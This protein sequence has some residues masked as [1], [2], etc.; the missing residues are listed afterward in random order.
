MWEACTGQL[1]K[2]F[3]SLSR[4]DISGLT[5]DKGRRK[6][7]LSNLDGDLCFHNYFNGAL[8]RQIKHKGGYELSSLMHAGESQLLLTVSSDRALRVVDEVAVSETDCMLRLVT[9]AHMSD[10][11]VSAFDEPLGL[12]ATGAEDGLLKIWD[13]EFM[14]LEA[15]LPCPNELSALAFASPYPLLLLGDSTGALT[16]LP[17]RPWAGRR[18]RAYTPAAKWQCQGLPASAARPLLD[19]Q[20]TEDRRYAPAAIACLSVV[21]FEQ[22]GVERQLVY[23]ANASG[24]I[25]AYDL[26]VVLEGLQMGPCA[27]GDLPGQKPNFN[28]RRKVVRRSSGDGAK[29]GLNASMNRSSNLGASGGSEADAAAVLDNGL[30]ASCLLHAWVAHEEVIVCMSVLQQPQVLFTCSQD[31]SVKLWGYNGAALGVLTWGRQADLSQRRFWHFP[32][33]FSER[34]R[35]RTRRALRIL[36]SLRAHHG[37]TVARFLGDGDGEEGNGEERLRKLPSLRSPR[38]GPKSPPQSPKAVPLATVSIQQDS[39]D[40][41][42]ATG[43]NE[44]EE[45]VSRILGQLH[46]MSTWRGDQWDKKGHKGGELGSSY[47]HA[48]KEK[49]LHDRHESAAAKRRRRRRHNDGRRKRDPIL[50]TIKSVDRVVAKY[51]HADQ[52]H[53]LAAQKM[54]AKKESGGKEEKDPLGCYDVL[55]AAYEERHHVMYPHLHADKDKLAA[56]SEFSRAL[57]KLQGLK[58]LLDEADAVQA[59]NANGATVNAGSPLPSA[60]RGVRLAEEGGGPND[61]PL[62]ASRPQTAATNVS[63]VSGVSGASE[64]GEARPSNVESGGEAVAP[65]PR[66]D[67]STTRVDATPRRSLTARIRTSIDHAGATQRGSVTMQ[68][69]T[70]RSNAST[71]GMTQRTMQGGMTMKGSTGRATLKLSLSVGH[72]LL[73]VK[74][75]AVVTK[76][77]EGEGREGNEGRE[78]GARKAGGQREA[79]ARL[80]KPTMASTHMEAPAKHHDK[81]REAM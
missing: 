64:G 75:G 55:R 51:A 19:G 54:Y 78:E 6:L 7:I 21:T 63:G 52:L 29:D 13:A 9:Q 66:V 80:T 18:P 61:D 15:S 37:G 77:E 71:Q 17:V 24:V 57:R 74:P 79:T 28:P 11:C 2:E 12:L 38:H 33:D 81:V 8:L 34:H 23:V 36:D 31:M 27:D 62:Q 26:G 65:S 70:Q 43:F 14:C 48:A 16:L 5:L 22:D 45:E 35:N 68:G 58:S 69:M 46:G 73:G 39:V 60:R 42:Q 20:E 72:D 76:E 53:L 30:G 47:V 44:H 56:Q 59:N 50:Q 10:I 49:E 40:V 41:A 4:S 3:V 32:F 67:A 25:R 1:L